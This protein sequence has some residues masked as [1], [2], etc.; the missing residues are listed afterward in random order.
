M[1]RRSSF[2]YSDQTPEG[3]KDIN[4]MNSVDQEE[5]DLFGVAT[6]YYPLELYQTNYDEVYR[7]FLGSK[8][9]KE[10]IQVRSFFKVDEST[11]HG[12]NDIG[13]GQVAERNGTVWFN[14]ALIETILGR[15]PMIGDVV[16]NV[17]IKQ[18]FEIYALSKE[19]HRLGRPIRYNCKVRL[20]QDTI[21]EPIKT[22]SDLIKSSNLKSS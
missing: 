13:I 20:H 10:P 18:R 12:M 3:L 2:N 7:D 22:D 8:N 17:Q 16:E 11:E 15:T 21:G 14:I 1:Y 19:T 5:F 9:F 6:I 4:F